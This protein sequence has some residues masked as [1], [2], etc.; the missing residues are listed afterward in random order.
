VI[1]KWE[2]WPFL[3]SNVSMKAL[4]CRRETRSL[5][6]QWEMNKARRRGGMAS[7]LRDREVLGGGG[8]MLNLERRV[9]FS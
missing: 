9:E 6:H 1:T 5:S 7:W 2:K 4:Y 8:V 3:H